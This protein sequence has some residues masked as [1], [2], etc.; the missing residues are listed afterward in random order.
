MK[1]GTA[2]SYGI[3]SILIAAVTFFGTYVAVDINKKEGIRTIVSIVIVGF[4]V[5]VLCVAWFLSTFKCPTSTEGFTP[6][7]L[8]SLESYIQNTEIYNKQQM[9]AFLNEIGNRFSNQG[10]PEEK[11]YGVLIQ[12]FSSWLQKN[13]EQGND[14]LN[15]LSDL[16]GIPT[17]TASNIAREYA[18]QTGLSQE[19]T[20]VLINIIAYNIVRTRVEAIE[21]FT[22]EEEA[23]LIQV[24]QSAYLGEN[25]DLLKFM[26]EIES[27]Y[28]QSSDP[29]DK[30]IANL[31]GPFIVYLTMQPTSAVAIRNALNYTSGN[32]ELAITTAVTRFA[33]MAN[34]DTAEANKLRNA[35]INH[36]LKSRHGAIS[37]E[38]VPHGAG[39]TGLRETFSTSEKNELSRMV[40]TAYITDNRSAV[41]LMRKVGIFYQQ[42]GEK[43]IGKEIIE[44]VKWLE[45][46]PKEQTL[47]KR[48]LTLPR[49]NPAFTLNSLIVQ[50]TEFNDKSF[51]IKH[52]L[53]GVLVYDLVQMRHGPRY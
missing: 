39:P 29:E 12:G 44:M 47:L 49:S 2:L 1:F 13:P 34:I 17:E 45:T 19:N 25:T 9:Y 16:V 38:F 6:N 36:I 21:N 46:H 26:K 37:L 24:V 52:Q 31:L 18:N 4:I 42:N 48:A 11:P 5:S 33:N 7:S 51:E 43:K 30:E 35:I 27:L 3:A 50:Y 20:G 15:T 14:M 53:N 41:N 22:N 40:K 32:P 28:Q 8:A 10:S 23:N